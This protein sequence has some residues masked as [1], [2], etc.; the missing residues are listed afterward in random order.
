MTKHGDINDKHVR[1]QIRKRIILFAGNS[2]LKI[3][4]QLNCSSGKRLKK[5][6]R[7]FFVSAKEAIK[8]GF[9]PCAYCMRNDYKKWKN[10]FI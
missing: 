5:E 4:G 10:D 7:V 3:Y 8:H 1:N 9:R 6:N 2:Q